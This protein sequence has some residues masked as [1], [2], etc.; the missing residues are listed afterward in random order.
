MEKEEHS[1]THESKDS[2][3]ATMYYVIGAVVLVAV[4]AGVY[5][6]RPKPAAPAS[7]EPQQQQAA[8]PALP[9]PTLGPITK[10][11]CDNVYYNPVIGFPK[12]YVSA[13]GGDVG[14]T[15]VE[16]DFKLTVAGKD[17]LLDKAASP[18]TD[19]PERGGKTFRCTTKAL[20]V[21]PQVPTKVDVVLTDD[22]NNTAS[23]TA[24]FL[25]PRP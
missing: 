25:F 12:Y 9:V 17:T 10:L 1:Q 6:M 20:E 16:C 24:T 4:V 7:Q 2:E 14:G 5:F 8:A 19:A 23:C 3:N 18:L 21:T 13:Q 11:G 22:Q 15:K